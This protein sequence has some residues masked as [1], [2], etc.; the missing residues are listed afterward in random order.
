M[1]KKSVFSRD[2]AK[3]AKKK[4]DEDRFTGRSVKVSVEELEAL[5]LF[6]VPHGFSKVGS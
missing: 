4:F 2:G 1:Q 5:L 3:K 6:S